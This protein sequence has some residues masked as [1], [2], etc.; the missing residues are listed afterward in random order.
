MQLFAG[1]L[2]PITP[3]GSGM[4]EIGLYANGALLD[5][6]IPQIAG[7]VLLGYRIGSYEL[8]GHIG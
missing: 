4:V 8:L 5:G 6:H 7:G 3:L 2:V 1:V